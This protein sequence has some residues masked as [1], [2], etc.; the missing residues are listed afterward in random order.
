[1]AAGDSGSVCVGVLMDLC[2]WVS[3][4]LV[5]KFCWRTKYA[6]CAAAVDRE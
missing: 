2:V 5:R 6:T 3:W 4:S 1:L